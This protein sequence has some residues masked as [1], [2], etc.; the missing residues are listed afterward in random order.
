[1]KEIQA[2]LEEYFVPENLRSLIIFKSGAKLNKVL[3][4]EV[5]TSDA[6]IIHP[7]LHIVPLEAVLEENEKILF[8]ETVKEESKF[9]IYQLGFCQQ[10][11]RIK[12]FV[13]TDTVDKSIP[14]H[15]QR[16]RL[17]HLQWHLKHT[18]DVAY[19]LYNQGAYNAV[20][21]MA[22]RR[23]AALLD[24]FL[25]DSLKKIIIG[26]IYDSPDADTR[27]RKELIES[28]LR[29]HRVVKETKAIEDLRNDKPGEDLVSS[30]REVMSALN[31][32]LVRKLL[33]SE[34]LHEK[35]YVCREHHYVSLEKANC[36]FDGTKLLPA[37]NV[38]DEIMEIARLH[39]VNVMIIEHRQDL[40][41]KYG[42]IAA[43]IYRGTSQALAAE[44]SAD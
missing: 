44:S 32:F 10:V 30:L 8:V 4:L 31:L 3:G 9:L 27:D 35:G 2:F 39:G 29:E 24:E 22:E 33:V 12:S 21:L 15:V 1:M 19:R 34:G 6:F 11:D 38:V 14:G 18:A 43:E 20:I 40:L 5:R 37:E 13:P 42:G 41:A 28:T 17:A 25:H 36:P 23:V 7:D 26:R 16:H